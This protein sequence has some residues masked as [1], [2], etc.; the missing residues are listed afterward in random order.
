MVATVSEVEFYCPE[1]N[2]EFSGV[3]LPTNTQ[4]NPSFGVHIPGPDLRGSAQKPAERLASICSHRS[5]VIYLE[6]QPIS[7]EGVTIGGNVRS[8]NQGRSMLVKAG[9][10]DAPPIIAC[11]PVSSRSLILQ[12]AFSQGD[13][14][15]PSAAPSS[16]SLTAVPT[17]L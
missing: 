8:Y 7:W 4:Q 12:S 1:T 14:K 11:Q 17:S 15:M 9:A 3:G 10:K 5:G 6:L 2:N 16:G 13:G